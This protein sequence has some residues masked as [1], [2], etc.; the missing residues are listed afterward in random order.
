[1]VDEGRASQSEQFLQSVDIHAQWESDYLNPDMDRFYDFAFNQIIERLNPRPSDNVL[2][3]GCGYCHHT[4]RLARSGSRITAVDFSE[5][6]LKAAQRTVAAAGLEKQVTLR[7][8]DLTRLPFDDASFEFVVSWGVIM[9]I[10][11]MEAALCEMIRIL[12]PGGMMVLGENNVHS[13]DVAV[14]ERLTRIVKIFLGRQLPEMKRTER[15]LEVWMPSEFGGLLVRKTDMSYLTRFLADRGLRR[16][17]RTAGQFTEA[18][19]NVPTRSLKRLIYA[20]NMFYFRFIQWPQLAIG[21]I[22]YFQKES[23]QK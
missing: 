21:N 15:G 1:M 8:A 18:Y 19:T 7:R 22:L 3:A 13:P 16:T 14:R 23:M 17:A 20:L 12:K 9:H 6:A 10:P 11:E 2:D 5:T 4:V